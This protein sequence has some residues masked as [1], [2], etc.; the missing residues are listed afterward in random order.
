[1]SVH[2]GT[3]PS[4]L[5]AACALALLAGPAADAQPT[6]RSLAVSAT[7]V[8]EL[9]GSDDLL[10]VTDDG[11]GAW[12][13]LLDPVTGAE[14]RALELPGPVARLSVSGT[15]VAL[16]VAD[17][18]ST[19]FVA[20]DDPAVIQVDL[21]AWAVTRSIPL[22]RRTAADNIARWVG[23]PPG[24]PTTVVVALHTPL[25]SPQYGGLMVFEDGAALPDALP[26]HSGP[27]L[28]QFSPDGSTLYGVGGT[29][30]SSPLYVVSLDADGVEEVD[31]A[32]FVWE[33]FT[34]HLLLADGRLVS[35]ELAVVETAPLERVGVLPSPDPGFGNYTVRGMVAG[36]AADL[37]VL[38]TRSTADAFWTDDRSLA[39]RLPIPDGLGSLVGPSTG[40]ARWGDAGLAVA[41]G[42]ALLLVESPLFS[43]A[44]ASLDAPE[45]VDFPEGETQRSLRFW[46]RNRGN[47]AATID[48]FV[49]EGPFEAVPAASTIG[50]RDSVAVD[51]TLVGDIDGTYFGTLTAETAQ[52]EAVV[53]SVT[54]R[55]SGRVATPLG[56]G[57]GALAFGLGAPAPSPTAGAARLPYRVEE[58]G[59]VRLA[60]YDVTG[61]RV[62][63]VVDRE[64]G[65]GAYE[66][67]VDVGGL[68]AAVYVCR[69]VSGSR[70]ATQ[71]LVV[72]R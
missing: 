64:L 51:V 60:L 26:D 37:V 40:T 35:D 20:L 43:T 66:A 62:R 52:A 7:E 30:N 67:T 59:R 22:P 58:A 48:D 42:E 72:A 70:V 41:T 9:P 57:P 1:M 6:I 24:R 69:L 34:N 28:L 63:T 15:G 61:R 17:D 10:V 47:V 33:P 53:D 56:G 29:S 8:A 18:G 27:A 36:R 16:A 38:L 54:V 13:R 32:P 65:P 50:P 21:A 31:Q 71:R 25:R 68:P 11:T 12:L 5:A 45:A 14:E 23:V 39:V 4:L 44:F 2:A 46:I 49:V 55:L 3:L 19:A